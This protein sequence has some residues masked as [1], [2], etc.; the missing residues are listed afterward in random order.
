M[1]HAYKLT[2]QE[3]EIN[4]NNKKSLGNFDLI[5]KVNYP[6][7]KITSPNITMCTQYAFIQG[8]RLLAT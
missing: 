7:L 2:N 8:A 4:Q 5:W 3:A 6:T 1:M